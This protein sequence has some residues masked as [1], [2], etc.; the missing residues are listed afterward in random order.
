[1]YYWLF[2][3][4][5]LC[6]GPLQCGDALSE[7]A[8]EAPCLE[9]PSVRLDQWL[10]TPDGQQLLL[11]IGLDRARHAAGVRYSPGDLTYHELMLLQMLS[12]ERDRY[13]EEQM[14]EAQKRS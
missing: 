14:K 11:V 1:V 3:R 4:N 6:P 12:E 7:T 13:T 8:G 5:K 9:C 2:R 10:A